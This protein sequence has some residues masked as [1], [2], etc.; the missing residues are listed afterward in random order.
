M[1]RPPVAALLVASLAV[2]TTVAGMVIAWSLR[3]P[4]PAAPTTGPSVDDLRCGS[5]A[6]QS[7]VRADVGGD[8]VEVLIGQGVGRIRTNGA[9]GNNIFELTIAESG[10]A[11]TA[12]SLECRDAVVS[13]CLVHGSVGGEVRGELLVRRGGAWSRAQLPYV[14]SGGY[15]G[16]GDVNADGVDD[17]VAVQRACSPGVDCSR[18]FAQVFSL[19]GDKAELGCTT[20]VATQDLLPGWP[21]VTPAPAQLRPCGA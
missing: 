14:A 21:D 18:R 19:V 3:P 6:C 13:V 11:I 1:T 10:A 12:D 2:A 15:L 20:V 16:L 7:V 17:V 4:E 8:A 5:V 9:S